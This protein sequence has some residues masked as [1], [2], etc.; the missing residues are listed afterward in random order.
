VSRDGYLL[1][2][3]FKI[4][5]VLIVDSLVVSKTFELLTVVIFNLDFYSLHFGRP[6]LHHQQFHVCASRV[7]D[8]YSEGFM[9]PYPD[10][11][12]QSVSESGS[13]KAK[14][15]QKNRNLSR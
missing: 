14:M 11:D 13:E 6:C 1:G 15:A 2:R 4:Y 7:V 9:D 12:Y 10:Q 5:S 3:T 8:P